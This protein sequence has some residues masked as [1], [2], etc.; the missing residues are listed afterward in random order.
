MGCAGPQ[1]LAEQ[2]W[3]WSEKSILHRRACHGSRPIWARHDDHMQRRLVACHESSDFPPVLKKEGIASWDGQPHRESWL[4]TTVDY[5]SSPLFA[6]I[7]VVW[8]YDWPNTMLKTPFIR[9]AE[10][11]SSCGAKRRSTAP[12]RV[13]E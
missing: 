4:Y 8:E 2:V 13:D 3:A 6:A 7:H 10:T 9:P 5:R 12:L 11:Q 1:R